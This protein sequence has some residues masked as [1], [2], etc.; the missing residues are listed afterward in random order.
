VT[1]ADLAPTILHAARARPRRVQDGRSL[2]PLL[3]DPGREWGRDLLIEGNAGANGTFDALR[4]YR[5]VYVE[6]AN[7][8]RELYDLRSDPFQL[9]SRHADPRYAAVRAQLARRLAALQTCRGRACRRRPRL[10][11]ATRPRR[12]CVRRF[13]RAR[14]VGRDRRS[15]SRADFIVR[16][17]R[18]ARDRRAPFAKRVRIRRVRRGRRFRFRARVSTGDGRV[19]TLDR[20]LRRCA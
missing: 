19:V 20:R 11:L 5:Y 13:V 1:N 17:R 15:V 6:Y 14:V 4:T 8:E 3:D 2:F 12:R 9:Q 16:G 10:R 18:L 7:G